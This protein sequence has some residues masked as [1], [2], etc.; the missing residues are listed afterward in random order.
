MANKQSRTEGDLLERMM[1]IS[2]ITPHWWM[3][4]EILCRGQMEKLF[5]VPVSVWEEPGAVPGR[6]RLS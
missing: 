2:K 1:A 5:Q 4:W 6:E 3:S